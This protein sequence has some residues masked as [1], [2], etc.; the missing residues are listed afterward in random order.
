MKTYK[1]IKFNHNLEGFDGAMKQIDDDTWKLSNIVFNHM[2]E[3]IAI[4][5]KE[6]S[7]DR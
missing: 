3:H 5:E 4:F 6:V 1:H 2:Y 7:D